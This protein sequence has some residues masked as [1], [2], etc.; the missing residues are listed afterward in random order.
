MQIS[1]HDRALMRMALGEFDEAMCKTMGVAPD[2][3]YPNQITVRRDR[4]DS[5]L[6]MCQLGVKGW[7][8]EQRT[9]ERQITYA[10]T[11]SGV[12]AFVEQMEA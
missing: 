11:P 2:R 6:V 1:T 9:T 5:T 12:R 8:R 10:I 7:A 3:K 4:S